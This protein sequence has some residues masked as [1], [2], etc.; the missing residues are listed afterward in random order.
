MPTFLNTLS[1][2]SQSH[3]A[4]SNV[5]NM[6]DVHKVNIVELLHKLQLHCL[7]Y[8]HNYVHTHINITM[9]T[10]YLNFRVRLSLCL[11]VNFSIWRRSFITTIWWR[12]IIN[13]ASITISVTVLMT[14]WHCVTVIISISA[15]AIAGGRSI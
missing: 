1:C 14:S 9:L 3:L 13:C 11:E 15:I 12:S 4:N 7:E 6:N 5:V 2:D 8:M 10:S